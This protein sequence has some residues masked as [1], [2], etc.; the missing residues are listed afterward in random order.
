VGFSLLFSDPNYQWLRKRFVAAHIPGGETGLTDG[1][2]LSIAT[3]HSSGLL[4]GAPLLTWTMVLQQ[5]DHSSRVARLRGEYEVADGGKSD[6]TAAL[7]LMERGV[8]TVVV[9]QI[10]KE[11]TP[12]EDL[13]ITRTLAKDLFDCELSAYNHDVSHPLVQSARYTCNGAPDAREKAMLLLH[14]FANNADEFRKHLAS[15]SKS[16]SDL[17]AVSA[18][19][20]SESGP[21][22]DRFPQSKTL[23]SH[24]DERLIRAYYLFG[25]YAAKNNVAP[26]LRAR[27]AGR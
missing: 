14:P 10:S 9:S 12:F 11:E 8:D 6:N 27:L 18:Y 2:L 20:D 22:S 15:A 3:A 24:Y 7:P 13:E 1:S 17:A 21:V 23:I 25:H 5:K 16:E 26:L 19:L 4:K